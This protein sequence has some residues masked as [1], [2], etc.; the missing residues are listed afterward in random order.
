MTK[1]V[2]GGCLASLAVVLV[3]TGCGGSGGHSAQ[4]NQIAGA[5]PVVDRDAAKRAHRASPALVKLR[6]SLRKALRKTGGNTGVAVYDLTTHQM[7]FTWGRGTRRPPASVEK[8][9]TTVALLRKLGPDARVRTSVLG[10][11]HLGSGG[12]WHGDLYLRGGGDPTLGDG[13]FNRVWEYGYGPTESQLARRLRAAGVRRVT[14]K[15]IADES[16]FDTHRGGPRT[17]FAPDIPDFGGQ[18]SALVFDHGAAAP[19]YTPATFAVKQFAA[20]LK[21]QH[22]KVRAATFTGRAPH[23]AHR[24]ASVSSPP[25]SVML[26]LMDIPSDDLFAELLTKQLGVRFRHHGTIAA[27]AKVISRV[28]HEYRIH[29]RIVDG[30]GLS[31]QDSSSPQEVVDLLQKV[32]HTPEGHLVSRSLPTVGVNG[33][34]R[35]IGLGTPAQGRCIGKT[36]T[37]NYVTNLAGYC[38]SRGHKTLAFAIFI[39]GP[40]NSQAIQMLGWLLGPMARY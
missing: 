3:L 13:A 28:M 23:H 19:H 31:P 7:L 39:D 18:L 35:R 4:Q 27:G 1:G 40:S 38:A 14:G 36:G 15:L 32:W 5:S 16:L 20:T 37:L 12:T 17:G 21:A 22:I 2:K 10:S 33:T 25:I 8:L 30:S 11:G 34:T 9:Y 6:A 24:L 26:K 29:P